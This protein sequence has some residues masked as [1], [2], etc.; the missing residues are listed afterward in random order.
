MENTELN[1]IKIIADSFG[2][3]HMVITWSNGREQGVALEDMH[4]YGIRKA[5]LHHAS[6]IH[7]QVESG[8]L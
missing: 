3:N 2:Q 6:I 8:V 1:E 7:T 5:L 4:P